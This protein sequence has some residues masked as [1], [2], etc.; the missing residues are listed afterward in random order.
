MVEEFTRVKERV[1]G[2]HVGNCKVIA[3]SLLYFGSVK[4]ITRD[5]LSPLDRNINIVNIVD[6]AHRLFYSG[7]G[8]PL[9]AVSDVTPRFHGGRAKNTRGSESFTRNGTISWS[10]RSR[11][12]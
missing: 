2:A 6:D 7:R 11:V 1:R 12:E 4:H 10:E 3:R 8:S 9:S 5:V